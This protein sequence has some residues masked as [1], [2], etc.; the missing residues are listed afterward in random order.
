MISPLKNRSQG[1]STR[2]FDVA[3]FWRRSRDSS[4]HATSAVAT[5]E[6]RIWKASLMRVV[7]FLSSLEQASHLSCSRQVP[8][9]PPSLNRPP[10]HSPLF[11][12]LRGTCDAGNE[13]Q[14][15]RNAGVARVTQA[16]SSLRCRLLCRID[17]G[18]GHLN[19][20]RTNCLPD[21]LGSLCND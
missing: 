3:S 20:W 19:D 6:Y 4:R 14:I 21:T 15:R 11:S 12:V 13:P 5:C 17:R 8:L 16:A 7:R 1:K 9:L 2:E 18:S 10:S